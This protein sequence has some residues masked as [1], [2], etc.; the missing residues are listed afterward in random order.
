MEFASKIRWLLVIIVVVLLLVLIGW[1]LFSIA[2]NIFRG[3]GGGDD[4]TP[5]S[6]YNVTSTATARFIVDGPVVANE[7]HRSF[8][9]EVAENVVSMTVYGSYGQ[10]VIEEKS[11]RNTTESFDTFLS[12]LENERVTDRFGDTDEEDDHEEIG[13]CPR[14]RRYIVELDSAVRRWSTSCRNSEGTAGFNMRSIRSLFEDQVP[15]YRDLVR[16]TGL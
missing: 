12:A 4:I 1:G 14:G 15:N 6:S 2:S 5:V 7:N 9:I 3:V 11:Y 10:R 13:V 8:E 16:G